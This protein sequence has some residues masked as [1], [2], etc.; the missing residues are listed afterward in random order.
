MSNYSLEGAA[1]QIVDSPSNTSFLASTVS[2]NTLTY[3][4]ID[5]STNYPEIE[6]KAFLHLY[7][8]YQRQSDTNSGT[9]RALDI[10]TS[11]LYDQ[12][13]F[14]QIFYKRTDID[15][16]SDWHSANLF[17]PIVKHTDEKSYVNLKVSAQFGAKYFV[18]FYI[19]GG[20]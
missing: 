6:N 18:Y 8:K 10:S 9:I 3:Y 14:Y 2:S 17:L 16:I 7:M 15:D 11:H 13:T 19:R 5:I 4:P 1:S 12:S 20:I